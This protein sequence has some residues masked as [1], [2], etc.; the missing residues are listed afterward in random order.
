ML[1]L[2][3]RSKGSRRPPEAAGSRSAAQANWDLSEAFCHLDCCDEGFTLYCL[4]ITCPSDQHFT[5]VMA[6]DLDY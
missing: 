6:R 3:R 2:D 1:I 5:I 4:G